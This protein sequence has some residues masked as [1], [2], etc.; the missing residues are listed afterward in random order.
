MLE[1][2]KNKIKESGIFIFIREIVMSPF[3]MGAAWPSSKKLAMAM[4]QKVSLPVSDL[5]VELGGGTGVVTGAL[6]DCNIPAANITVIERSPALVSYLRQRF[7]ALNIVE[8]DARFLSNLLNSNK[9]KVSVIISSLP[10]RTLPNKVVNEIIDQVQQLLKP[11]G[12]F[13]QF[14]YSSK[15]FSRPLENTN[16]KLISSEYVWLNFPPARL[17]VFA[18]V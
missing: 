4:A 16:F 11:G 6:L 1:D 15:Y 18:R 17:D 13:I 8:G 5:V 7:P 12:L 10:L 3:S 14:T 2:I 9:E